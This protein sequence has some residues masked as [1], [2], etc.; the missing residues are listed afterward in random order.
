MHKQPATYQGT[1]QTTDAVL[2]TRIDGSGELTIQTPT[3]VAILEFQPEQLEAITIALQQC[4]D[5]RA[6]S[7]LP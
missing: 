6:L 3:D 7:E 1:F 5:L 4:L 2:T